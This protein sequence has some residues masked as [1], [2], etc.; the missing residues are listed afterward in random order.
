MSDSGAYDADY[1]QG[2]MPTQ[3]PEAQDARAES[4]QEPPGAHGQRAPAPQAV[5]GD[6]TTNPHN[7]AS[8][9]LQP[10]GI[11]APVCRLFVNKWGSRGDVTPRRHG[12]RYPY[13]IPRV[14]TIRNAPA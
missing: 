10:A 13:A 2:G 4:A 3:G 5:D 7:N 12:T 1:A 6:G 14:N 9:N 11:H 8:D